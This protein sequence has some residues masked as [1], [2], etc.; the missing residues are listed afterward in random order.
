MTYDPERHHRR[1]L[2]LKGY[3]YTEDGAYFVTI[4][5]QDRSSFF[6]EVTD[7]AVHPN[8][9]GRMVRTVWE[10]LPAFYPGVLVDEFVVMPN[11]IHGIVVLADA[12]TRDRFDRGLEGTPGLGTGDP[13]D[14]APDDSARRG[15]EPEMGQ[16]REWGP[17]P[18][19]P[20]GAAPTG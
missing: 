10:E 5:A 2:R 4:V 7:A 18:G 9:A 16:A 15:Q 20:R 17:G 11:H 19:R 8:N 14:R 13:M 12:A 3:D 6:G 1:S